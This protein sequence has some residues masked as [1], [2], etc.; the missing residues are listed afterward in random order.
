MQESQIQEVAVVVKEEEE[1]TINSSELWF[2]V[3]IFAVTFALM[4]L[5]YYETP[6]IT[7]KSFRS[8]GV[9]KFKPFT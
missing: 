5:T 3:G 9:V 2:S 8:P 7:Q 4:I 1:E 6:S